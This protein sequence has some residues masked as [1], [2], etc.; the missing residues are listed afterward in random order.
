M[1]QWL[2]GKLCLALIIFASA[3]AI[4]AEQTVSIAFVGDIML[5]E[6]PGKAI[7]RGIDPFA[8]FASVLNSADI[9][10]GNL[11]CVIA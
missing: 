5:A 7:A 1:T 9:R 6:Q 2:S 10:V 4:A 3:N 8:P 11:E